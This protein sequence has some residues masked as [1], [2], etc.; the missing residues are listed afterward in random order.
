MADRVS[1]AAE[2]A[3]RVWKA[4]HYTASPRFIAADSSRLAKT[5]IATNLYPAS[6][7][8]N[9]TSTGSEVACVSPVYC[10]AT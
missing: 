8:Q 1:S 4:R 7:K 2:P 6:L 5:K 3:A 9:L 10:E